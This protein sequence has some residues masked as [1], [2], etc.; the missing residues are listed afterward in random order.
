MH[1]KKKLS[2]I[3]LIPARLYQGFDIRGVDP[4]LEVRTQITNNNPSFTF[5]LL[6]LHPQI[7][8]NNP[9]RLQ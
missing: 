2:N 6:H 5:F 4:E 3:K 7:S 8:P 1:P 9:N